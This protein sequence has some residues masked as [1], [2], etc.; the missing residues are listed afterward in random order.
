MSSPHPRRGLSN[1]GKQIPQYLFHLSHARYTY[2]HCVYMRAHITHTHTQGRMNKHT[3]G[4]E[5]I[6]ST[7]FLTH[8]LKEVLF[9]LSNFPK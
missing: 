6:P 2:M 1:C 5:G 8:L 9:W 4:S 7:Q 3:E